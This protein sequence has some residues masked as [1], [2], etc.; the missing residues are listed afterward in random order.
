MAPKYDEEYVDKEFERYDGLD[1]PKNPKGLFVVPTGS[2]SILNV[3]SSIKGGTIGSTKDTLNLLDTIIK[4]CPASM[5]LNDFSV[6]C[7]VALR[8][9]VSVIIFTQASV[10]A[11]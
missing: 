6:S 5:G 3:S 4:N 1:T 9:V 10:Y 2:A 11:G 8:L 7:G